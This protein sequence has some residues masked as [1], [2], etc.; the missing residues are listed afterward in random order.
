MI[1]TYQGTV[2]TWQCDFMGHMN[3]MHYVGMFDQATWNLFGHFDITA[4]YLRDNDRG[5]V[6]LEQ[7]IVYQNELLAGDN[8]RIESEFIWIKEKTAFFKHYM[9]KSETKEVAAITELTGLHMDTKLRKGLEM[10][11]K[12]KDKIQQWIDANP[13]TDNAG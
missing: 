8:V 9:L 6:A 2:Y 4:K 3:V 12:F 7:H 13:P 11:A 10:P 1:Q 5:M